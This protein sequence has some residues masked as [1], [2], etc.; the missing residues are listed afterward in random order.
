[1]IKFFLRKIELKNVENRYSAQI[2]TNSHLGIEDLIEEMVD[3]GT[4]VGEADIISVI[5]S[6]E[7][8]VIKLLRSGHSIT[9]PL[10]NYKPD[11]NGI[12]NN[13][14]DRFDPK[15]HE[16]KVNNTPGKLVVDALVDVKVKKIEST[17]VM[18]HKIVDF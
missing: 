1:M 8:A 7:T 9:T 13:A 17:K 15:R 4:T 3:Q 6:L 2:K 5:H 14:D 10:A 18:P 11:I 16:L 12:F